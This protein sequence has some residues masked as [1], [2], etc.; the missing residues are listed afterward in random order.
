MVRSVA[1]LFGIPSF[2]V[3]LNRFG[4]EIVAYMFFCML[5]ESV[6][7]LALTIQAVIP[8]A[9][10]FDYDL[11]GCATAATVGLLILFPQ[12]ALFLPQTI[13]RG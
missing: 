5:L 13:V 6:A 11:V 9:D 4:E 12:I 1:K 8:V 3:R 2:V 10:G 7:K